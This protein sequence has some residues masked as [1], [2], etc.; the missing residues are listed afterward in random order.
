MKVV[1]VRAARILEDMRIQP[2]FPVKKYTLK[3][4][5]S[6]ITIPKE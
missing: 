1:S 3:S 2:V 5:S 4:S 6:K